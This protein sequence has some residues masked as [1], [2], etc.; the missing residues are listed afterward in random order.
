MFLFFVQMK[1]A[2]SFS[3]TMS[4]SKKKPL[5]DLVFENLYYTKGVAMKCLHCGTEIPDSARF[6][7]ACGKPVSADAEKTAG[8]ASGVNAISSSISEMRGKIE[9]GMKEIEA[10]VK[11][12][13]ENERRVPAK[14][15]PDSYIYELLHT[16][17]L[18]TK[19]AVWSTL[20]A[21]F[22]F[23]APSSYYGGPILCFI[24]SIVSLVAFFIGENEHGDRS[25]I[26]LFNIV[27]SVVGLF[28]KILF[29]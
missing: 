4:L 24:S 22:C 29:S 23:L 28:M 16:K 13:I 5:I 3:H 14:A 2:G 26:L 15:F 27:L 6:C 12:S 17:K 11:S 9:N 20:F 1:I 18:A 8:A 7:S 19:V 25:H 10:D 21:W